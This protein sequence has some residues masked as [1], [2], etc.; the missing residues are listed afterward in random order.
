M[1]MYWK[2]AWRVKEDGIRSVGTCTEEIKDDELICITSVS[3]LI[4]IDSKFTPY[5][6]DTAEFVQMDFYDDVRKPDRKLKNSILM[7]STTGVFTETLEFGKDDDRI[8][9]IY[10]TSITPPRF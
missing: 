3:V 10:S 8:A 2:E 9:E 6:Y 5:N 1:D 7:I 4:W